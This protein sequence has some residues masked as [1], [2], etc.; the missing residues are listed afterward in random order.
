MD[1]DIFFYD[2]KLINCE[3]HKYY[4]GVSNE[5]II[6]NLRRLVELGNEIQ[7]RVPCI[8]GIN[9]S[10]AQ[11]HS[12]ARLVAQ[13]GVKKIVLLPYNSSAKAKYE[14]IGLP[15]LIEDKETQN[16]E[17]M[18]RLSQICNYEGLE[19]QVGA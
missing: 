11:I 1:T 14:L 10:E 17:Y 7:V 9:D 12:T 18:Y 8:P 6:G 2:I 16:E 19:V 4:T 15:F 3:M 5:L 13:F